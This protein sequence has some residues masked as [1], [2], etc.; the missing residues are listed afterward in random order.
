MEQKKFIYEVNPEYPKSLNDFL[1]YL[2]LTMDKSCR[3][4]EVYESNVV[5]FLKWIKVYKKL[6]KKSIDRVQI[7]N[8]SNLE[9][10]KIT[11]DNVESFIQYLNVHGGKDGK[12]AEKTTI[13][14]KISSI[15]MFFKYLRRKRI[16]EFNVL[17]DVDRLEI[18]HRE[19][20]VLTLDEAKRF[21]SVINNIRDKAIFTMYLNMGLRLTELVNLNL[22]EI[23]NHMMTFIG[24]G[25]KERSVG[26][27]VACTLALNNWIDE[28]EKMKII[29]AEALFISNRGTRISK[30]TIQKS[31]KVYAKNAGLDE[32]KIH[33]HELRHSFATIIYKHGKVDIRTLQL[34]LGH[35]SIVTT[36]LYTHVDDE[37]RMDAINSIN[38]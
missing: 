27:N 10:T 13:N 2:N 38:I 36:Q 32:N 33:V 8:F 12:P 5:Q 9:L 15:K 35:G 17:N 26:M 34:L 24:K 11:L 19:M 28:R 3:T 25:D 4:I 1:V 21:L 22:D 7:N 6:S 31:I 23:K 29:D 30:S 16:V 37:Q 14:N 18:P 20:E